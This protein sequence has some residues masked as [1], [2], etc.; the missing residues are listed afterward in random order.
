MTS[1]INDDKERCRNA[2]NSLKATIERYT[3]TRRT[4]CQLSII[5]KE[6][7]PNEI[8]QEL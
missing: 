6:Y 8:N 4:Y 2:L 3:N 1:K 5:E 7:I